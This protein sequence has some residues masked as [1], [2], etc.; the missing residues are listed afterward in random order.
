M[1]YCFQ[2]NGERASNPKRGGKIQGKG[3]VMQ[4]EGISNLNIYGTPQEPLC[5]SV[6]F[7]Y[8]ICC[9]EIDGG[10]EKRS[11]FY[12]FAP[13]VVAN[14]WCIRTTFR[15]I[16]DQGTRS[17]PL[18]FKIQMCWLILRDETSS[19]YPSEKRT[20]YPRL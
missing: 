12:D 18:K 15:K 13:V 9:I 10:G 20:Y 8:K 14:L 11:I 2:R 1:L 3:V 5:K 17:S 16:G 6:Y 19:S 7:D 4:R